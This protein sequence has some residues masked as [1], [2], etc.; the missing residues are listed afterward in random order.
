MATK[1]TIGT[2][3]LLCVFVHTS[4]HAGIDA[5]ANLGL[6]PDDYR[7]C[8]N[9]ESIDICGRHSYNDENG[10][11]CYIHI[12]DGL[13]SVCLCN[14]SGMSFY[15]DVKACYCDDGYYNDPYDSTY[16]CYQCPSQYPLS[17]AKGNVE[18]MEDVC[19]REYTT[20]GQNLEL[21]LRISMVNDGSEYPDIIGAQC[22]AGYWLAEELESYYDESETYKCDPVGI[23]YYSTTGNSRAR[24]PMYDGPS[25][26]QLYANTTGYGVG[27][28]AI[29]DCAIPESVE[30]SDAS[31]KWV[32]DGGCNF[33][34]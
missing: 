17:W 20:R 6:N 19:Y 21:N 15:S 8:S 26:T 4:A 23:E 12:S 3:I 33:P 16:A 29:T 28:S 31:G 24:C 22:D 30:F 7:E 9:L 14:T 10:F 5:L 18:S 11:T 34:W 25:G 1:S 32:Y 13:D 2:N 27:A